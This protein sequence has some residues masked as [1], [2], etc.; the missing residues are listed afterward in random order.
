MWIGLNLSSKLICNRLE[1][2]GRTLHS[3]LICRLNWGLLGFDSERVVI[4]WGRLDR[5]RLRLGLLAES[6]AESVGLSLTSH[7][8]V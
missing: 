3:K 7:E 1:H 8:W 2:L 6:K 4:Y 5:R